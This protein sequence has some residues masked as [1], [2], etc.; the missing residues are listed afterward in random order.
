M[1]THLLAV[2]VG[3][4]TVGLVVLVAWAYGVDLT[5]R[6]QSLGATV[7]SSMLFGGYAVFVVYMVESMRRISK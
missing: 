2:L 5:Q 1:K 4:T 6:G 7:I 3:L